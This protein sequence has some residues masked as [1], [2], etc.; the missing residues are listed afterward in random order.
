MK[1]TAYCPLHRREEKVRSLYFGRY[2][3]YV[4]MKCS[5]WFMTPI[6][7]NQLRGGLGAED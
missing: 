7:R 6:E 2:T 1:I 4:T 3:L 5:T